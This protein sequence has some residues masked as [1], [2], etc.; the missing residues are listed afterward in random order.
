MTTI[1]LL[2]PGA[3]GSAVGH[4]ARRAG[5]EVI[6]VPVGR[7]VATKD[8]AESAGLATMPDLVSALDQS[9]VVLSICPPSAAEEVASM[10]AARHFKGV[11]VDANA[12][13]PERMHRIAELQRAHGAEPVD[14]S[15][16]GP[17]PRGGDSARLYL[18]GDQRAVATVAELFQDTAVTAR[19][20]NK[21]LGAAS[22]LKMSFAGYQ[23]AARTLAAVAHA[24]ADAHHVSE[25]LIAEAHAMPSAILS[26]PQYLPTVAARAWRWAPEMHEVAAALHEVGLPGEMAEATAATLARWEGDRDKAG[27]PLADVL[28]HL[29]SGTWN[30]GGGAQATDPRTWSRPRGRAGHAGNLSAR[31]SE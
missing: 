6:W 28:R 15:I 26:D 30:T 5:A 27:L 22:A 20:M 8:R 4:Q 1:T 16:V 10:V 7:S 11:Y 14:G 12:V 25:E 31:S 24:L 18:S 29:R 13:S 23:K 17:P 3:M 21:P 19:P 9:D 2:H